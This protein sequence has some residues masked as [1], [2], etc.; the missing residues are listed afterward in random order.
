MR[1]LRPPCGVP[2][3][4]AG[5]RAMQ[6]TGAGSALTPPLEPPPGLDSCRFGLDSSRVPLGG[7]T[8]RGL[9]ASP[10]PLG[11][12]SQGFAPPGHLRAKMSGSA[13]APLS[14][15]A[16]GVAARRR[17]GP[18]GARRGARRGG[19]RRRWRR[20]VKTTGGWPVSGAQAGAASPA[21]GPGARSRQGHCSRSAL[22]AS[23]PGGRAL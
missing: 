16:P 17:A 23:A 8:L 11:L 15:A 6:K 1:C 18:G 19:A 22:R 7:A 3:V 13:A 9:T 4:S 20:V 14:L 12:L 21:E 2:L 5:T 10:A